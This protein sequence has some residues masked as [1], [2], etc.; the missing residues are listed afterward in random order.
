MKLDRPG[1]TPGQRASGSGTSKVPENKLVGGLVSKTEL[2]LIAIQAVA[3]VGLFHRFFLKQH[4]YS[5]D[6]M[7]DWAHAWAVPFLSIFLVWRNR[8]EILATRREIF[9]PGLIPFMF[10][11]MSYFFFV[12]GIPNHMLQGSSVIICLFGLVLMNLGPGMMKYMFL[13][14]AYL[15]CG[16][17]ISEKVMIYITFPLQLIASRGGYV[18]LNMIGAL[19]GFHSE[20]YGNTIE[21]I[22][23]RGTA[24]MNI[25]QACSGLR[26]LIAF[27]ALACFVALVSCKSWWQ[28]IALI[29]MAPVVALFMNV[30]RVA[31]LGIGSIFDPNIATGDAHML[32]GTIL[33]LPSLLMFMGVVWILGRV[34]R[35][36]AVVVAG[37]PA[38]TKSQPS[39]VASASSQSPSLASRLLRGAYITPLV[40]MIACAIGM[41]V[42]IRAYGIHLKKLAIYAPDGRLVNSI[43][44]ETPNW[45]RV[46]GDRVES[47]EMI[48][49]LGTENYLSRMYIRKNSVGS[50]K[51]EVIDLHI[52]YYTG[53][54][55]TVPHVP[56]R[57]FVGGGMVITRGGI[58]VPLKLDQT[59]WSLDNDVPQDLAGHIWKATL[60]N[61]YGATAGRVRLPRD[62]QNI[63]LRVSEFA[64]DSKDGSQSGKKLY[65]GYFFIANGGTTPE[66]EM[67]RLLAFDLK[68]E[69]AFYCKVQFTSKTVESP[70]E[71]AEQA[72]LLLNDIM[73]DLMLCIPD[74]VQVQTGDY[75]PDN[76]KR[77]K[78]P[79]K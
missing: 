62:P 18:L 3:F 17:T 14:I 54:I 64:D 30:V 34:S 79:V 6:K 23:S 1:Q 39:P 60:V 7:Q 33:L 27:F 13:P 74:W 35:E 47:K 41:G 61:Q 51:P 65:A 10:G 49:E 38:Q 48:E 40:I 31:I 53:M 52:A 21:V 2:T 26:M 19:F 11:I 8:K 4:E 24:Q 56:D 28:R 32:I 73:P 37:K 68:D 45:I 75:P 55:D 29:L 25:A 67:V 71:L 76:P 12:V 66:S 70:E 44:A 58:R 5:L 69:Y 42:A 63:E 77:G 20:V 36:E 22:S 57:C 9:W 15:A 43:P 16:M 46:G 50:K 72:S 59:R 78:A